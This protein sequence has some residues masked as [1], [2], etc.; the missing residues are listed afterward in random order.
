MLSDE[1]ILY[2]CDYRR[3]KKFWFIG[4]CISFKRLVEMNINTLTESR[5]YLCRRLIHIE[6]KG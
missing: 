3:G 2:E 4:V 5:K 1:F 6:I